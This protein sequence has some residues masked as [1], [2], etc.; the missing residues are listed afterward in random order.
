M[1]EIAN[2][3]SPLNQSKNLLDTACCVGTNVV[4][5]HTLPYVTQNAEFVR[6][7]HQDHK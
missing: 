1:P 2:T 4:T 7:V 3:V 6:Q 5:A